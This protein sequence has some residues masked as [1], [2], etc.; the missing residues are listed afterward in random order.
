MLSIPTV[1]LLFVANFSALALVWAYV[2]RGH[3]H[4][5]PAKYW[6]AANVLAALGAAAALLRGA[7]ESPLPLI[8]GGCLMVLA[9]CL[10]AMGVS[11]FFGKEGGWRISFIAIA[12]CAVSLTFF[13]YFHDSI[14]MRIVSYSAANAIP[15]ALSLR[16]LLTQPDRRTQPG[17]WLTT[18]ISALILAVLLIRSAA[19]LLGIG[20]ELLPL[21]FNL[22]QAVLVVTLAFLSMLWGISFLLLAF[23]RHRDEM[24]S[25]ALVDELTGVANRRQLLQRLNDQCARSQLTGEPFAVLAIDLDGFKAINDR[26]GHGA[27]DNCLRNFT[28]IAQEQLRQDDLLAR[29][30]GDEFCVVMP[31]STVHDGATT[32]RRVLHACL[33]R[34]DETFATISASIGVAQWTSDV[35]RD[36]ERLIAAADQ[37]LYAAKKNGKN[38]YAVYDPEPSASATEPSMVVCEAP[39]ITPIAGYEAGRRAPDASPL[40]LHTQIR[41]ASQG[42]N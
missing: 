38:R 8:V 31:R 39:E 10:G 27:G 11:R 29:V 14:A 1:W 17:A 40:Q 34:R 12:I 15:I 42:S 32:A 4:F 9:T 18:V 7:I 5:A 3:P 37:A 41:L 13:S 35:G 28:R 6:T 19:A 33:A 16:Y 22:F 36:L 2:M 30:G 25:L 24:A 23:D 21:H 26:Y 20:G